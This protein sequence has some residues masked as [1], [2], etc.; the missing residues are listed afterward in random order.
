[1]H[2]IYIQPWGIGDTILSKEAIEY[3]RK[4]KR[5]EKIFL[6]VSGS[7]QKEVIEFL[8]VASEVFILPRKSL[9]F[10]SILNFSVR[11]KELINK[12]SKIDIVCATRISIFYPIYF[13]ILIPFANVY[14]DSKYGLS[15]PI[16]R[17]FS[18]PYRLTQHRTDANIR[19][20][21]RV[22]LCLPSERKPFESF[23]G[24]NERATTISSVDGT[25]CSSLK[26]GFF[27]GESSGDKGINYSFAEEVVRN[28]RSRDLCVRGVVVLEPFAKTEQT[29]DLDLFDIIKEEK[30]EDLYREISKLDGFV[31]GDVGPSHIAALTGVPTIIIAGPTAVF[32]SSPKGS[33]IIRTDSFLPCMP[34]YYSHHYGKCIYEKNYCI[35]SVSVRKVVDELLL[36]IEKYRNCSGYGKSA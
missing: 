18:I 32:E 36:R 20:A 13:K 30:I 16:L 8:G 33:S 21:M 26:I 3:F 12:G 15:I 6:V 5:Y 1:M 28:I 31:S 14:R 4:T 22:N 25:I 10:L 24:K 23:S 17:W 35:E 2:L 11:L 7:A 9:N 27:C 19:I 29:F 34:C